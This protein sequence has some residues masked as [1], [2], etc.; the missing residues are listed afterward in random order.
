MP[1]CF[2]GR[3]FF[4]FFFRTNRADFLRVNYHIKAPAADNL[5]A[6]PLEGNAIT[7]QKTPIPH[8]IRQKK[9]FATPQCESLLKMR[10][11]LCSHRYIYCVVDLLF[12]AASRCQV[13]IWNHLQ[14]IVIV[15]S[16][17]QIF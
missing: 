17:W 8:L 12:V 4:F 5:T 14:K 2:L 9:P 7:F 13:K 15:S 1:Q 16:M 10:A 3:F 11:F 6:E